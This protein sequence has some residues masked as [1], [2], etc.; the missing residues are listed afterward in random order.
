MVHFLEVYIIQMRKLFILLFII[1][2][3]I[4]TPMAEFTWGDLP[5]NQIDPQLITE[6][7]AQMIAEHEA[8]PEAHLGAGESLEQHKT[9][10]T[11]DH[12]ESSIVTDKIASGQL[13]LY[14]FNPD[15]FFVPIS[16]KDLDLSD[17]GGSS[18]AGPV[19]A[20]LTTNTMQDVFYTA[21][22]GG[23]ERYNRIGDGD[24]NPHFRMRLVPTSLTSQVLYFGIGVFDGDSAIGYKIENGTLKSVWWDDNPTEHLDTIAGIDLTVP[25]NYEVSVDSEGDINWIIDGFV[26]KTLAY[27]S[28]IAIDGGNVGLTLLLK[29]TTSSNRTIVLYQ[30]ILE[31]DYF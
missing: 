16:P 18:F 31:Q 8:D 5:K 17:L 10:E 22:S 21:Y 4:I 1:I 20:E 24:L 13:L 6:A 12:P 29:K 14:H 30:I 11:L 27:P 23:D 15:R 28:D 3:F 19:Y 7:I 9:N 26:V 2:L 25:H